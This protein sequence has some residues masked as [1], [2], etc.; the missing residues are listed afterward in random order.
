[1]V[2]VFIVLIFFLVSFRAAVITALTIPLALLFAFIFLHCTGE[3]RQP[4]LHRR[5]R[6]RHHH[7]RHRGDGGK[8]LPRARPARRP[9]LQTH[10]VILAAA[11]DVDR[12]IFYS[13]AVIIAGYLADLC[14]E[15]ACRKTVPSDGGHHGVRAGR[16]V[17]PHADPGAGA[18]FVL[19]Q[20]RREGKANRVYEWFGREYG[21]NS[22]GASII[23][24]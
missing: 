6:F 9:G 12:P 10:E 7:R 23:P 11:Q 2:L 8:H 19:V 24:G 16:R 4:A 20:R 21:R 14:S 13:V 15:R 3:A 17:D 5:H 22:N 18:G 1:M